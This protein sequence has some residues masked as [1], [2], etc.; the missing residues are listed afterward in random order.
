MVV[1]HEKLTLFK[2]PNN[3]SFVNHLPETCY[4][5]IEVQNEF[6]EQRLSKKQHRVFKE[7]LFFWSRVVEVKCPH[8][9]SKSFTVLCKSSRVSNI[10]NLDVIFNQN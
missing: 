4:S 10:N 7:T 1:S 5:L 8:F 2:V 9:R 6:R 3:V